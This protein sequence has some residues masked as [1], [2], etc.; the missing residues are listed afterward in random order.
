MQKKFFAVKKR[1][2]EKNLK[3]ELSFVDS[4]FMMFKLRKKIAK[5]KTECK[6]YEN[7]RQYTNNFGGFCLLQKHQLQIDFSRKPCN[8]KK[9]RIESESEES[10]SRKFS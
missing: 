2:Q 1:E 5:A 3:P 8:T 9:Q 10:S 4:L 7:I 6:A